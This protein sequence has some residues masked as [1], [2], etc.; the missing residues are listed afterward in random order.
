MRSRRDEPS[1]QSPS[2]PTQRSLFVLTS[3]AIASREPFPLRTSPSG[4]V[5]RQ[6]GHPRPPD[7]DAPPRDGLPTSQPHAGRGRQ[8]RSGQTPQVRFPCQGSGSISHLR[9]HPY[10][11]RSLLFGAVRRQRRRHLCRCHAVHHLVLD[12]FY[13]PP[14]S[15]R[16]QPQTR[17]TFHLVAQVPLSAGLVPPLLWRGGR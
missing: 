2:S 6:H 13:P 5:Q 17:P 4:A 16:R 11:Y 7:V 3:P 1:I 12:H 14:L 15:T 10:G 9:L 8:R